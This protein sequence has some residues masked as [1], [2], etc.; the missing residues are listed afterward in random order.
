M[1]ARGGRA[2][3]PAETEQGDALHHPD[4][5]EQELGDSQRPEAGP[6]RRQPSS[7]V[8]EVHT[9]ALL[10][11]RDCT[12][13]PSWCLHALLPHLSTRRTLSR[14]AQLMR[15]GAEQF[16]YAVSVMEAALA[17]NQAETL[18]LDAFED[19][20][21]LLRGLTPKK[22]AWACRLLNHL[23]Y[24]PEPSPFSL[25]LDTNETR[26]FRL[27][28]E[29]D[30][31]LA[32]MP[33]SAEE[34][35]PAPRRGH[36]LNRDVPVNRFW[37]GRPREGGGGEALPGFPYSP[38]AWPSEI[39]TDPLPE[40]HLDRNHRLLVRMPFVLERLV[41]LLGIWPRLPLPMG[42]LGNGVG[43]VA[44]LLEYSSG[45]WSLLAS[46]HL[47]IHRRVMSL[48]EGFGVVEA[49]QA[50]PMSQSA[51]QDRRWLELVQERMNKG[52][53]LYVLASLVGG[54]QRADVQRRLL[55]AGL[56]Q[57]L[58][59]LLAVVPWAVRD[60]HPNEENPHGPACSCGSILG[61]FKSQLLRLVHNLMDGDHRGN[62]QV[63]WSL[64][65]PEERQ[66]LGLDP[67][68]EDLAAAGPLGASWLHRRSS[69]D[70]PLLVERQPW[71]A[72]EPPMSLEDLARSLSPAPLGLVGRVAEVLRAEP[73]DSNHRF[74]LSACIEAFAR[75][76]HPA[77]QM[78][79]VAR[80]VLDHVLESLL[81]GRD[82][83]ASSQRQVLF[84]LL[85]ELVKFN[86]AMVREL[87]RRLEAQGRLDEFW[88][89]AGTELTDSNVFLR[90]LLLTLAQD[91]APGSQAEGIIS[92]A[93]AD[94]LGGLGTRLRGSL[95]DLLW[96]LLGALRF[97]DVSQENM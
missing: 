80:G 54:C 37:L 13:G 67:E 49:G 32:D 29:R 84:D 57:V 11:L 68:A 88:R 30:A 4:H 20:E 15:E 86:P 44:M 38:P 8:A 65:S 31:V 94:S 50:G 2:P 26:A 33:R 91:I 51:P 97:A 75:G 41:R 27:A 23:V 43:L 56:V 72:W 47:L 24:Q 79:L 60:S 45:S 7:A 22:L 1:A 66:V 35:G 9:W 96:N 46:S 71:R 53:I 28:L 25:A 81:D 16:Y 3:N 21:G 5:Q 14:I 69:S 74:W 87:G 55:T 36:L 93:E 52:E 78:Y 95:L 83:T 58:V 64:L 76:S 40:T 6:G 73:L 19:P 92:E 63:K 12:Y 17:H 89:L 82:R 42:E 61:S 34:P 85:G 70:L 62:L 77:H 10:M 39:A 18:S 90:G 59:D 48:L